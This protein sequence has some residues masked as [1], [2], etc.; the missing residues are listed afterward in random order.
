M[1]Q[2]LIGAVLVTGLACLPQGGKKVNSPGD[3]GLE[4]TNGQT[5]LAA[6][7]CV[8]EVARG[9]YFPTGVFNPWNGP[10]DEFERTYY[11][12]RL[13]AMREPN[14]FDAETLLPSSYRC[15]VDRDSGSIQ[16]ARIWR[17]GSSA[18]LAHSLWDK[19]QGE[20]GAMTAQKT[21]TLT[22]EQ[23]QDFAS[24]VSSCGIRQVAGR[25]QLKSGVL[26][27][28]AT[29]FVFEAIENGAYWVKVADYPQ[30]ADGNAG[31]FDLCGF[32]LNMG[33]SGNARDAGQSG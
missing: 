6:L 29:A 16:V 3:D 26:Y 11:S 17:C 30:D 27:M 9:C 15:T 12:V 5:G 32:M 24:R 13:A 7:S 10:P 31:L 23:W 8:R 19:T 25:K 2:F 1:R 4:V 20:I 22:E 18:C 21:W 33:A 14:L 28:H